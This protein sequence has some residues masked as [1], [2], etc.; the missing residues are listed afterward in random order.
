MGTGRKRVA[1]VASFAPSLLNF[2]GDLLEEMRRRGHEVLALAPDLEPRVEAELTRL[3]IAS[4][5]YPLERTGLNPIADLKSVSALKK[6]FRRWKPDVVTGY[7]PKAAIYSTIAGGQAGVPLIVPMLTGL[8][9]AF[10]EGGGLKRR[11]V[12]LATIRLYARAFGSAHAAIFHNNDDRQDL[13]RLAVMPGRVKRHVV[14]GSGVDLQ[15]YREAPLP[16]LGGGLTF[17]MIARLVRYKGIAEFCE[18]AAAVRSRSGTAR[19]VLIG[20]PETGPAGFPLAEIERYRGAVEYLGPRSDIRE[21]IAECH[22]YVLPSYR[23][24]MPRTVLEAMAV[25]RPIITTDTNG[26]RDTVEPLRTGVLV[27][28]GDAG[29][30]AEAMELFLKRPDLIPAMARASRQKAE[31]EFDVRLVTERTMRAL[32]L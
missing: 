25:G 3:G 17:L 15:A 13:E 11:L 28:V 21:Q 10:Q 29:K 31:Q 9:Y 7:T 24:G 26:C 19:F 27:P 5:G 18:A 12:R 30:L 32:G 6:I 2:R 16:P 23:E 14:G 22:V 8:G 20:P 4:E 1:V